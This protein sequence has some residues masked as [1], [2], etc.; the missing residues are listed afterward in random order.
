M[1]RCKLRKGDRMLFHSFGLQGNTAFM[2]GFYPFQWSFPKLLSLEKVR[3]NLAFS[4][5][6]RTFAIKNQK[7]A[8]Q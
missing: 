5:F 8:T 4:S 6:I 1:K 2:Q 3:I 7:Q